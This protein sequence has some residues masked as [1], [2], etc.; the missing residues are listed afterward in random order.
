MVSGDSTV[1]LELL[2]RPLP[3][4]LQDVVVT[5]GAFAFVEPGAATR[6][7]MTRE[8][9]ESVPRFG[10]DIF[11][12]VS[13]LPG[14]TSGDYTAHFGIRGGRHDETLIMLDGLEIYEPY[15]LKDF[16]EGAISIVDAE[17]IDGVEVLTGGFPAKYGNKR[18]GVF[19]IT[20]K[21]P[22][23]SDPRASVGLSFIN[24]RAMAL[25]TF[26]EDRGSSVPLRHG[27]GTWTSCSS[28]SRSATSRRRRTS[29]CSRKSGTTCTQP[30][31]CPSASC[32]RATATP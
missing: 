20:S 23:G 22:R 31:R 5:P 4:R 14:L 18:S 15:H 11:H 16:N 6:Q 26:A 21:D 17:T 7:V 9:I 30:M 28:C 24:A 32:T 29:T 3:V 12:A 13:R 2:M 8:D 25:G 1:Q 27:V 10:E 19:R